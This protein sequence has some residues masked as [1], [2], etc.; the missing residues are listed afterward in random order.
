VTVVSTHGP[1]TGTRSGATRSLF[2]VNI[3]DMHR[4]HGYGNIVSFPFGFG[5]PLDCAFSQAFI[6]E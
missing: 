3:S 6:A 5:S 1:S 4:K 2:T